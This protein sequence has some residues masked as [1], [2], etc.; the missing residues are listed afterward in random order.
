MEFCTIA[1]DV[2][3]G[4][5]VKTVVFV[6]LLGCTIVAGNPA[7]ALHQIENK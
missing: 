5:D 1:P 4:K 2:K 6:N 3:L 7:Q